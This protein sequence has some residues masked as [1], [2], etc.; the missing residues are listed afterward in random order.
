MSVFDREGRYPGQR[1]R[2]AFKYPVGGALQDEVMAFFV[3]FNDAGNGI[4]NTSPTYAAS[5]TTATA[6]RATTAWTRLSTGLYGSVASGSLR[7]YYDANGFYRGYLPQKQKINYALQSDDL[8]QIATW[9]ATTMTTSKTATGADGAANS[10]TILT[11]TAGNATILQTLVR[12][13]AQRIT[14]CWIKRRT[15]SGVI[16]MTQD[17]GVTWTPVTVTSDWTQVAIAAATAANPILGLQIVTNTDAVDVMWFLHEEAAFA[18]ATPVPTTTA[19]VTQNGDQLSY[20]SAGNFDE[21][22]GTAYAEIYPLTVG[23]K[24][25]NTYPLAISG[26]ANGFLFFIGGGGTLTIYDGTTYVASSGVLQANTLYKCAS[27]WHAN[28]LAVCKNGGTLGTGAFDGLLGTTPTTIKVGWSGT[29][30]DACIQNARIWTAQKS[31]AQLL[32]MTS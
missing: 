10:A 4:V 28:G 24:V 29:Q 12:A 26:A 6:T 17:N 21:T 1:E 23:T 7:S 30:P 20:P 18:S 16:N 13:S 25:L 31:N 22:V 9:V 5:G 27:S 19:S 8:T 14:S 15:G 2:L 3:P 32:A 11:A